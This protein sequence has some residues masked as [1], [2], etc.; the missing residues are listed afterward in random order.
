MNNFDKWNNLIKEYANSYGISVPSSIICNMKESSLNDSG[1]AYVYDYD[2]GVKVINLDVFAKNVYNK[3]NDKKF[4]I[5]STDAFLINKNNEWFFI[6]FKDSAINKNKSSV[7]D[8]VS[9]KAYSNC[10]VLTDILCN[11]KSLGKIQFDY[12]NPIDF[13]RNE[14]VFI[15]VCSKSKNPIVSKRNIDTHKIHKHYSYTPEF[16]EKYKGYIYKDAIIYTDEYFKR[17]FVNSFQYE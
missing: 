6:E 17:E 8:S 2:D 14:V 4:L 1:D 13:F 16:M 3:I 15:L 12:S 11:L 7:K 10:I 5:N 9:K